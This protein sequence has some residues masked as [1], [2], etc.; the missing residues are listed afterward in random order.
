MWSYY[1]DFN[2]GQKTQKSKFV[3]KK[4]QKMTWNFKK[5]FHKIVDETKNRDKITFISNIKANLKIL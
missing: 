4:I 5:K 1:W 3:V 2:F